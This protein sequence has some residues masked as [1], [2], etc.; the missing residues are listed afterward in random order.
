MNLKKIR[1]LYLNRIC[2]SGKLGVKMIQGQSYQDRNGSMSSFS[3]EYPISQ[4]YSIPD[5]PK[6]EDSSSIEIVRGF[7]SLEN[8]YWYFNYDKP[9]SFM[10]SNVWDLQDKLKVYFEHIEFSPT[11]TSFRDNLESLTSKYDSIKKCVTDRKLEYYR[12][13]K[14]DLN[15][16]DSIFKTEDNTKSMKPKLY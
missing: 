10:W 6:Y 9:D 13:P 14:D 5:Y 3:M 1:P 11:F 2:L 16:L 7:S 12:Y 4:I 8:K 15:F